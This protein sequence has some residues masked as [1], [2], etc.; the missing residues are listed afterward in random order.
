MH[1]AKSVTLTAVVLLIVGCGQKGP[2]FLADQSPSPEQPTAT[3]AKPSN[4]V[5]ATSHAAN[6]P[7]KADREA[8]T[9]NRENGSEVAPEQLST[10]A[11]PQ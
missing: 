7:S 8:D 3:G 10:P 11:A 9:D 2:L 6:N 4:Y 1:L 5:P